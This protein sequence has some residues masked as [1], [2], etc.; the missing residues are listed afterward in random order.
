MIKFINFVYTKL[1]LLSKV[2]QVKF[3]KIF[4]NKKYIFNYLKT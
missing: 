3:T 4:K 2:V 1:P